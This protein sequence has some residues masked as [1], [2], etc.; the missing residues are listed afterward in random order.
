VRRAAVAGGEALSRRDA[1]RAQEQE[2][3]REE[4]RLTEL[5]AGLSSRRAVLNDVLSRRDGVPSGAQEVMRTLEGTRLLAEVLVVQPGF[6]RALAAALGPIVQAVVVSSEVDVG[7]ALRGTGPREVVWERTRQRDSGDGARVDR[8]SPQGLPEGALDLWDVVEGPPGV[9]DSLKALVGPTAVLPDGSGI[10]LEVAGAW[11]GWRVV[12]KAGEVL[13]PGLHAARR[14]EAGVEAVLRAKNELLAVAEEEKV[15]LAK[16]EEARQDSRQAAQA[17]REAEGLHKKLEDDL[18][19][20]ERRLLALKNEI[21]LHGRRLEEA[22]TQIAELSER[23]ARERDA[24]VQTEAELRRVEAAISGREDGMDQ[25]RESL[26][27]VQTRLESLRRE[28]NQ[29]EEKK[30]QATLLE[31]RLKERC[32]AHEAERQRARSQ[33]ESAAADVARMG[34]RVALATK[35]VP[36][37]SGLLDVVERLGEAVGDIAQDLASRVEEARSRSEAAARVIREWGGAEAELQ[38]E[39]DE[40]TAEQTRQ[41]VE[42]VRLEDRSTVIEQELAELKRKH[43]APRGVSLE[44]VAS[45][46]REALETA[47]A[48]AEQRRNRIGLVNPLAEQ[49]CAEMEERA[50]FLTEQRRDLEASIAQLQSV[51]T[52]LDEHINQSFSSVFESVRENFAATIATVFPGAKGTLVLTE[53]GG[54]KRDTRSGSEAGER[55]DSAD[56]GQESDVLPGISLSVKFP[57]K[58]PRSMSLLSGGEKAMTAIAFLFALFLARPCPF[59]I[60][61]EVEASLDDVNIRRFL[62]LVRKY[63]DRTQFI[64]I[65]HQRQTMEIADTLYGIA[66]EADG[67]SRVLS[68]RLG[69]KTSQ[70]DQREHVHQKRNVG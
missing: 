53:D 41:R 63:R 70:D 23:V 12:T 8:T 42:R 29:L 66:L 36:A 49:E 21:D 62:S 43:M 67:T 35:Y 32:R 2:A 45:E 31:V 4:A 5:L 28:V 10:A 61:D 26:R 55:A 34:R 60:L 52:E 37:L 7:S 15:L 13:I 3:L 20:A 54:A 9:L 65:T 18:R 14:T 68:R 51:I 44:D 38:R 57:N 39:L 1:A 69:Q 33:R 24:A 64:I 25:A 6:E 47:L 59:Y 56:P 16:R 40:L 50:R 19:E 48:R 58:A 27:Q 22:R 46:S 30:G 17:A 11:S